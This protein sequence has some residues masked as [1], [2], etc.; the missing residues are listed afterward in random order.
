MDMQGKFSHLV[1]NKNLKKVRTDM[2]A[3]WCNS[4]AGSTIITLAT[5]P[6]Y[7]NVSKSTDYVGAVSR[8]L[9]EPYK[10]QLC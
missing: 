3:N 1:N 6:P 4:T 2:V 8:S 7:R 10:I 9:R 5:Q